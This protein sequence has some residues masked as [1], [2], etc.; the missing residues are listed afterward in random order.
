MA[1]PQLF[2]A[3]CTRLHTP[4]SSPTR[5]LVPDT[6]S[7]SDVPCNT[8][9]TCAGAWSNPLPHRPPARLDGWSTFG[10]PSVN[11]GSHM[12]RRSSQRQQCLSTSPQSAC[13]HV[14]P[15]PPPPFNLLPTAP[16]AGMQLLGCQQGCACALVKPHI[17]QSQTMRPAAVVKQL[18]YKRLN[19]GLSPS[20]PWAQVATQPPTRPALLPWHHGT[21][22]QPPVAHGMCR[23]A[24]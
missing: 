14:P 6:S 9:I 3:P 4:M 15:P 11:G 17:G 2:P 8:G 1:A 16:T 22:P 10:Q 18:Q 5:H 12:C 13:T 21:T 20:G 23:S 24:M 7:C 19:R